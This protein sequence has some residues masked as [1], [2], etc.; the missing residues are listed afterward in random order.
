MP[1]EKALAAYL[2]FDR[3]QTKDVTVYEKTKLFKLHITPYF[4]GK[5]LAHTQR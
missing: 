3:L 1:F 5:N 4:E 2:A